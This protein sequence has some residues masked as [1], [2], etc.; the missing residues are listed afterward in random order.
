[1]I[2]GIDIK[3]KSLSQQKE[4]QNLLANAIRDP[5]VLFEYLELP[6]DQLK[7]SYQASEKFKL[8]APLSFVNKI[9]KG[10]WNDPLL[11]QILPNPEEL[12]VV[13]GYVSDPVGD[14]SA[15]LSPGVL[16]KYHGRALIVTTGACAIHCRYCFRQE[17]PYTDLNPARNQWKDTIDTIVN[18]TSINEIILSGGDPLVLS[19]ERLADLCEQLVAI[20]HIDTLRLHTRLPV[21]LPERIDSAFLNWFGELNINKVMVI[22]ANHPNEIDENIGYRLQALRQV[23]VTVL[24]QSVL[25][26]GVNDNVD[27]LEKLSRA[28]FKYQILPYYLFVLDKV[29]GAAHFDMQDDN[30]VRL[31]EGLRD[32]LPGYLV[33][34]LV[35]EISGKRSKT[36]IV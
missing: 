27:T 17:Y 5:Q 28:L 30:G 12:K 32:R 20:P 33:P 15:G 3:N 4:W 6:R 11:K 13:E 26:K 10:N 21:A 18:D 7:Q 14:L 23:G 22:H 1:M 16:K 24:N 29:Q 19:D 2:T 8:L 25:L 9:E 34:K 35:R 36:P 31:V